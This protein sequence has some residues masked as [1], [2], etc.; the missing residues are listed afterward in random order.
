MRQG[1]CYR[2]SLPAPVPQQTLR[3][4]PEQARRAPSDGNTQRWR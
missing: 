4:V 2:R 1:R 3:S